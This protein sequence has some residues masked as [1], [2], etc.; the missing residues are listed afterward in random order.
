MTKRGAQRARGRAKAQRRAVRA[1][2][3]KIGW[4]VSRMA[5]DV[6]VN[7]ALTLAHDAFVAAARDTGTRET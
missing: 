5:A 3:A 4:W 7:R 1:A 6:A 2:L